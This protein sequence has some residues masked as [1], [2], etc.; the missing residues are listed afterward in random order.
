[1]YIFFFLVWDWEN[2]KKGCPG[3]GFG[4]GSSDFVLCI[5]FVFGWKMDSVQTRC[6]THRKS[7]NYFGIEDLQFFVANDH[8]QYWGHAPDI[9]QVPGDITFSDQRSD[10]WRPFGQYLHARSPPWSFHN[11]EKRPPERFAILQRGFLCWSSQQ[12]HAQATDEDP[13]AQRSIDL[14]VAR[15]LRLGMSWLMG[16]LCRRM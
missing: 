1:M 8:L 5:R 6:P 7:Q 16:G 4:S 13:D 14:G 2:R 9:G 15:K 11:F 10:I 12:L 3:C